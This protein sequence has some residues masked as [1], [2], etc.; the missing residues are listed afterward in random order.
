M[1]KRT[2]LDRM[3]DRKVTGVFTGSYAVNPFTGEE[4]PIWISEYVLAGYGTGAVMAVPAHDSRDY[5]FAKHFNLPIV[6]LIEG[7]DVENESFDAKEGIV[8]NS[9][10][11]GK[12]VFEDFTLNGKTV[13]EA[14][15]YTKEYVTRHGLGRVKVNYRLRDAIFSRQ[16]Y[17]G[18]PFPV[19]Y[20][21]GLPYMIPE[22]CLPLELPEIDKYQP[23]ESGEPPLGR[24][25]KWTRPINAWW[26]T[27]GSTNRR[28]SPWN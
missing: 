1:K 10:R 2:E 9:P 27:S 12:A 5:A 28:C 26:R 4:I 19:Y 24:A 13:K 22:A 8:M 17:W 11:D 23:T 6:P 18:E 16:R 3:S 15:A 20:K 7:A 25:K 14:I 21:N